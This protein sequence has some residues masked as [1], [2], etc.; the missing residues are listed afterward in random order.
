MAKSP[1]LSL[2]HFKTIN[3]LKLVIYVTFLNH[4]CVC[5]CL[6]VHIYVRKRKRLIVVNSIDSTALNHSLFQYPVQ[7]T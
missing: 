1:K 6:H 2:N 4:T 5:L 3:S 7:N